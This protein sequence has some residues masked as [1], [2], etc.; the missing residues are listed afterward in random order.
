MTKA[1]TEAVAEA[2]TMQG[3]RPRQREGVR[4]EAEMLRW[5]EDQ[6]RDGAVARGP[7]L[8]PEQHG[9]ARTEAVAETVAEAKTVQ[10][11]R[12]RQREDSRTEAGGPKSS[13]L[14]FC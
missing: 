3:P 1:V 8:M 12:P 14:R 5:H 11:P 9:G 10:G 2:K 7:R 13:T 6:G 4:M